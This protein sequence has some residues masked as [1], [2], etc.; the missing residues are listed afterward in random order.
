[1]VCNQ[2]SPKESEVNRMF[3]SINM[4]PTAD[5]IEELNPKLTEGT[6]VD[7]EYIATYTTTQTQY[8]FTGRVMVPRVITRR[9][10]DRWRILVVGFL[11][12]GDEHSEWWGVDEALYNSVKIGDRVMRI[13][14][15]ATTDDQ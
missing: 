4:I 5:L 9:H 11:E 12:N 13:T 2:T 1:M 7:K 8:V 14:K 15:E 3:E 10:P 6:V